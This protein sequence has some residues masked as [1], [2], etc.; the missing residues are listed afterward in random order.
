MALPT[1]KLDDRTF[2]DIVREARSMIPR[3]CPEWTDHNLSDPGMTLV[4]L[5]AWMVDITLYRMNK[6]PEKNYIKF[7]DLIGIKLASAHPATV[8]VT[9]R[10]SAPQPTPVPVSAGTEV[11]TI[12]TETQEAIVFTTDAELKIEVPALK[13]FLITRDG[14]NFVEFLGDMDNNKAIDLFRQVPQEEN[15]FYLGFSESLASNV[16]TLTIDCVPAKGTGVNPNDPPLAW[17]YWDTNVESW[18]PFEGAPESLAWLERDGTGAFNRRGEVILHLPRSFGST[19]VGLRL[20]YWIRCRV[21]PPKPEQPTY[22][23]TPAVTSLMASGT[24]GT[25]S[26]MHGVRVRGEQLGVSNGN[27]G[28]V[29]RLANR[30]ILQLQDMETVEVQLE[31]ARYERWHEVNDFSKSEPGD[32]HFVCD[33][34]SG[35]IRLGPGIRQPNGEVRQYGSIPPRGKLIRISSY[36]YG[37]GSIGN[38]GKNTLSVLKSSIPYI[39]SVTNRRAAAGGLDPETLDNAMMRAPEVFRAHNRAVTEADYEYLAM[40]GSPRVARARCIQP[41]EAGGSNEPP[42]GVVLVLI[43]P[44]VVANMYRPAPEQLEVPHEV[45]EEVHQYLDERRL[46]NNLLIV[47]EPEYVWVSAEARVRIKAKF[48]PL[49]VRQAVEKELYRFINP[50]L[51]GPEGTGWPFGRD[52]VV[53]EVYAHIQKVDGVE[54][55]EGAQIYPVDMATGQRGE[56]TQRLVLPRTSVLCSHE[57]QITITTE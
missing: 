35:E 31:G 33:T 36:R 7:M 42:P 37:G 49:I 25:V 44:S 8:D 11:A 9:F 45:K 18:Q 2:Q 41:Q 32:K 53:S 16:L 24:G 19:Q 6:V 15:A 51:G 13:H 10:L 20:A 14:I 12:R 22:N 46:L 40:E 39:A 56:A 4:E 43:I 54:Y 17:E 23:A 5:F 1:P 52:L 3:Y 30:P 28:Q 48:D 47:S 29:F 50:L 21:V 38:V 26:A 55:V 57:H 27:A 34:A